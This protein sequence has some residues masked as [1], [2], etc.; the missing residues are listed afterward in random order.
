MNARVKAHI[1]RQLA[2]RTPEQIAADIEDLKRLSR[3]L[4]KAVERSR[5]MNATKKAGA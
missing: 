4:Q 2:K 3:E 5:K 1:K